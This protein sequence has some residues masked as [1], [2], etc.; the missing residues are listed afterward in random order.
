V[1]FVDR[2]K[3]SIVNC[4]YFHLTMLQ[5]FQLGFVPMQYNSLEV[6]L[7]EVNPQLMN[8]GKSDSSLVHGQKTRPTLSH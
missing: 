1:G 8:G 5:G 7:V 3:E 4:E 2:K 6:Q